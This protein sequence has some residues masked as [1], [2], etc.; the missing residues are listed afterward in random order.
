MVVV[1]IVVKEYWD[2]LMVIYDCLYFGYGFKD[3]MG[4][5]MVVYLVGLE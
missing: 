4:Y 2:Y 3:N 5:G 1:L